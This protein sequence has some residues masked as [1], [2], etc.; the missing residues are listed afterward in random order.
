MA[1]V[2]RNVKDRV[3]QYPRRY[4]MVEVQ[5]GIFDL[6]PMPGTITEPGTP[7]NK[8]FLQ[9][10]EEAI[11]DIEDGTTV[12]PNAYSA[13][14]AVA[15][16]RATKL[17]TARKI[18]SVNFDG[19]QDITIVDGTKAPIAHANSG[20]TYGL[21]S[22]TLHG[23]VKTINGL[24]QASHVDGTALSAY[25][26]KVLKDLVD[27]A[28]PT[29]VFYTGNAVMGS[30]ITVCTFD[31][32]KHKNIAVN[33]GHLASSF[34]TAKVEFLNN[35]TALKLTQG[36]STGEMTISTIGL[37]STQLALTHSTTRSVCLY[38]SISGTTVTIKAEGK[39]NLNLS[40]EVFLY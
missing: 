19:T 13:N 5:P 9:P 11:E 3:V 25:Q 39:E 15:A 30:Q 32:T 16:E 20:N 4:Q 24:T 2:K 35:T 18:N 1:F 27:L 38:I 26:G 8:A 10:I 17:A 29:K 40:Y 7:I 36:N 12:V 23:H 6:I 22:P 14:N 34:K 21:G 28:N 37:T 33:A 31:I